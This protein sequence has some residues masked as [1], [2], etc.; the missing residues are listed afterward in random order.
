MSEWVRT[1]EAPSR[2]SCCLPTQFTLGLKRR[3]R[4]EA[5]RYFFVNEGNFRD[6]EGYYITRPTLSGEF[7]F[8]DQLPCLFWIAQIYLLPCRSAPLMMC[9]P[10]TARLRSTIFK[11]FITSTKLLRN[12]SAVKNCVIT[13]LLWNSRGGSRQIGPLADLAAN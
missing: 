6:D 9:G 12:T 13:V 2:I 8:P 5:D 1:E 10:K 3:T 4:Y 11:M 7:L